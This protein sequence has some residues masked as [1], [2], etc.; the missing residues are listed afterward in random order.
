MRRILAAISAFLLAFPALPEALASEREVVEYSLSE[1]LDTGLNNN[2]DIKIAKIEALIKDQDVLLSESVF[3][4]IFTGN[5][6]Y[7][8][9]QSASSSPLFGSKTMTTNYEMGITKE[10]PTGTELSI[11]YLDTREWTDRMFTTIN[12]YHKAELSFTARQPVLK[13]FLGY[14]DRKSV[15]L[16]KIE[17]EIAGIEAMDRIENAIADIGK[18]YWRLVF[19]YQNVALRKELLKQAEELYNRYKEHLKMG[20]VEETDLYE[21]EANMRIR[22]IELLLAQND[23]ITASNN[24]LFLLNEEADFIVMPKDKLETLWGGANLFESLNTAFIANRDYRMKKKNL[25]AKKVNLKMKE[26]SLWPQIDLVGTLSTSGVDRKF[27][28]A[29]RRLSTNKHPY[30]YGGIE[31]SYPLENREARGEFN[32]ASL[33]KEKA[34]LEILRV[35]KKIFTDVDKEVRV[36]NL[37]LENAKRWTKIKKIQYEKFKEE[38][39][40]LKY[41]RSTSKIVVDYQ[42]DLT[43]AAIRQYL[44]VLDYYYSLIDLENAKDTLL[45]RIGVIE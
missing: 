37:R 44:A 27:E 40:K 24:L 32:K 26:N 35:E 41:G 25:T 15:K 6:S 11:D 10:L 5:V 21:T 12:P 33:E 8:D 16:S 31:V 34:I 36:V 38:E 42:N 7:T 13:N 39:K 29:N 4:A 20:F 2:L 28:H 23:L 45:V 43:L 19:S 14:I 1:C 9:D 3:D 22:K 18:A 17:A 30:Y